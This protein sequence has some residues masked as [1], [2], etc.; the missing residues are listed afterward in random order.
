MLMNA[1]KGNPVNNTPA[2]VWYPKKPGLWHLRIFGSMAYPHMPKEVR[3]KMDRK[4][5]QNIYMGYAV[6]GYRL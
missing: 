4:T 6:N 2:E 3:N 1:L 5:C